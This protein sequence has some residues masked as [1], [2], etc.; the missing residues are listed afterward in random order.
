VRASLGLPSNFHDV[1][2]FLKFANEFVDLDAVAEA[3]A[4]CSWIAIETRATPACRLS[5]G[6]RGS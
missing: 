6:R 5:G 4:G 2:R 1:H 3:L